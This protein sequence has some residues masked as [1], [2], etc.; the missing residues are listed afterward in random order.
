MPERLEFEIDGNSSGYQKSLAEAACASKAMAAA[1]ERLAGEGK[2]TSRQGDKVAD[3]VKRMGSPAEAAAGATTILTGSMAK[4]ATQFA[5]VDRAV[6][7]TIDGMKRL[8]RV[9]AVD[10]TRA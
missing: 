1:M 9:A 6:R 4:I 5:L 3:S 10:T 2:D 7:A 8:A